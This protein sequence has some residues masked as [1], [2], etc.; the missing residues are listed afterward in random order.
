MPEVPLFIACTGSWQI[1][2]ELCDSTAFDRKILPQNWCNKDVRRCQWANVTCD[3]NEELLSLQLFNVPLNMP[4]PET[5]DAPG[6]VIETLKLVNCGLRGTLPMTFG[7]VSTL[8]AI[9]LS[10]NA[11]EGEWPWYILR[12]A[13]EVNLANNRLGG[14]LLLDDISTYGP[15]AN[16]TLLNLANNTFTEE[17]R[18]LGGDSFPSIVYFNIENNQFCGRAPAIKRARQ[19]RIGGN[20]FSVL[21]PS[22]GN[23]PTS[24]PLVL[25]DCDMSRV[26][27]RPLPPDWLTGRVSSCRYRYDPSNSVYSIRDFTLAALPT[28]PPPT[29]ATKV[30]ARETAAAATTTSGVGIE[31]VT[32]GA[33]ATT[34]VV[35]TRTTTGI[36]TI[37]TNGAW[38]LTAVWLFC[39]LSLLY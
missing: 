34:A 32:S 13:T 36:G 18:W 15:F 30:T 38:K 23:V 6:P 8:R 7:Q 4:L 26:P 24:D 21:E 37:V 12:R 16:L 20:Y 28:P 14:R 1:V 11:I 17:L 9:D 22:L 19:Y 25:S 27:F 33:T 35:A 5:I 3:R 31:P 2:D 39:F 10:N 29:N